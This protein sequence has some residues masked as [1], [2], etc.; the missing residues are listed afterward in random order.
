MV[1]INLSGVSTQPEP[2]PKDTYEAKLT[3]HDTIMESQNS[4]QPYIKFEFTVEHPTYGGRKLWSNASLQP[5]SQWAFKKM[6]VT[7]GAT[8]EELDTDFDTDVL[9]P[10]YYGAKVIVDVDVQKIKS[11]K[12]GEEYDSNAV[13][14][15]R[16]FSGDLDLASGKKGKS[17]F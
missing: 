5:Q 1:S 8:P 10:R 11:K 15:V 2:M 17:A 4:G 13:T 16:S 9:I 7:L 6:M 12:T 3:K 14:N